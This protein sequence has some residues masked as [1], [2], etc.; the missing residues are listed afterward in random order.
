MSRIVRVSWRMKMEREE[1]PVRSEF[2][3][4]EG[5]VFLGGAWAWAWAAE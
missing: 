5:C 1:D 2:I 4:P 3:F